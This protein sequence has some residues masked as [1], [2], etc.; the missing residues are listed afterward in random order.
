MRCSDADGKFRNRSRE[1]MNP[2]RISPDEHARRSS[3]GAGRVDGQG[4]RRKT[5]AVV[6]HTG[7]L[8]VR[9]RTGDRVF[10]CFAPRLRPS[11]DGRRFRAKYGIDDFGK[12]GQ[13]VRA[14]QNG[15]DL[16]SYTY[17]YAPRFTR[18][19]ASDT[20]N[21]CSGCH[22]LED[23]AYGFVNSDRF[24]AKLGRRI[25]FEEQV[26]LCYCGPSRG[27]RADDLRPRSA[28]YPAPRPGHRASPSTDRRRFE[29]GEI[30]A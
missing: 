25:S 18:R 15:Y 6:A 2:S 30:A 19:T 3:A 21:S 23:L 9:G 5:T 14:V 24:N 7:R 22:T 4:T 1:S 12:D 11:P 27:L 8:R 29:K 16:V 13:F 10:P 20:V 28:R 17:K 26:Q